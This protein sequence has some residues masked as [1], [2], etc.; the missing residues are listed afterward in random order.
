[1][2]QRGD[3]QKH[4]RKK[5][6]AAGGS[7]RDRRSAQRPD[8]GSGPPASSVEMPS[9]LGFALFDLWVVVA[10]A[11]ARQVESQRQTGT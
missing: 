2:N 6:P 11:G 3:L 5:A 8:S 10:L 4:G 9:H 1:M 7:S